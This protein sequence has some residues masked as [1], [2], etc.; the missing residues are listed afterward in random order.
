MRLP[1]AEPLMPADCKRRAGV[2]AQ[3]CCRAGPREARIRI[4]LSRW[5]PFG[6]SHGRCYCDPLR[7]LLLSLRAD[8]MKRRSRAG[9]KPAKARPQQGVEAEGQQSTQSCVSPHSISR[10]SGSGASAANPGA[11]R[12]AET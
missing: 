1:S 9:G 5:S 8:A 2:A 10:W 6:R 7:C 3:D 11:E 12:L 4:A